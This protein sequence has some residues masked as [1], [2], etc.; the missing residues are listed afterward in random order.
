MKTLLLCNRQLLLKTPLSA[1]WQEIGDIARIYLS[2][3]RTNTFPNLDHLL[4][5]T[6][7]LETEHTTD[8]FDICMSQCAENINNLKGNKILFYSGGIDS[9]AMIIAL[10]KSGRINDY[11][12]NYTDSSINEYP[13]FFEKHIIKYNHFKSTAQTFEK[14]VNEGLNEG[15]N[16]IIAGTG[17]SSTIY[18]NVKHNNIE[19][20]ENYNNIFNLLKSNLSKELLHENIKK[21]PIELKTMDDIYWYIRFVYELQKTYYKWGMITNKSE[22]Y[23]KCHCFFS[24]PYRV[25][26]LSNRNYLQINSFT[27]SEINPKPHLRKYIYNFTN[28]LSYYKTKN[29]VNSVRLAFGTSK[30]TYK[31]DVLFK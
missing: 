8:S 16:H 18:E 24:K 19:L 13:E 23:K 5:E 27:D 21:C 9:T 11:Q 10:I 15:K 31:R 7:P 14:F 20:N 30:Y 26:E 22:H 4:I 17:H 2:V 25:W 29:K 28:D 12:I 6:I 1:A 3:D